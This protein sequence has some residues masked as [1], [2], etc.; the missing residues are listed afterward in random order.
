M[1]Q[2]SA[3]KALE[4]AGFADRYI[5][6]EGSTATVELAAEQLHCEPA[7]IAKSMALKTADGGAVVVVT[8]GTAK[9]DNAKFKATFKT[10]AHFVKADELIE[11]VGHEMGGVSPIGCK[12]GVEV[13]LDESL[14]IFDLVY[15][16]CGTHMNAFRIT[17]EELAQM[18]KAQWVD[19]TK[20]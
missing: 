7:R 15:P 5:E 9:I 18:T 12:P 17:P 16:A 13:F 1:S 14:K 19:V 11:L 10:K 3:F 8:N 2:E 20:S 4:E 6:F